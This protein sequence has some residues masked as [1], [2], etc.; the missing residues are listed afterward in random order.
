MTQIEM[1]MT[2]ICPTPSKQSYRSQATAKHAEIE[3]RSRGNQ[4]RLYPYECSAGGHWHLTHHTPERQLAVFNHDSGAAGLTAV[5]NAFEG[6]SIRHV[7][8]DQPVWIGRDVCDAVGISKYRDALAQLDDDERVSVV[9]D[10]PGGPQRMS[11]VTEAGIYS[12]MLISRSDKVKPFKRWLTHEV[13]PT[14]RKTGR[15]DSSLA[16]PDRKTLAQWVVDAE[17]RADLAEAHVAELEPKAAFYDELMEADGTYSMLATSKML[18]W[19]RNVMMRELRR[20]GVLQGNNLPYQRY[21][22]H[23]KVTPGTYVHPK[24]GERIPTAT[25]TVRPSG[26]DFLRKKLDRSPVVV[27]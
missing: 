23:F 4:N 16:L 6:T 18:G 1:P 25:T 22:H 12:L 9:V 26:V 2:G 15:Y 19:G 14:I 27:G 20:S 8:T 24:T 21:E 10:T 5:S 17:T 3:R 11:A 13:L 7:I